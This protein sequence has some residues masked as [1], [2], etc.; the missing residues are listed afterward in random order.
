MFI[1]HL[2]GLYILLLQLCYSEWKMMMDWVLKTVPS[3]IHVES[4]FLLVLKS[5]LLF[6]VWVW[7]N[8]SP[9]IESIPDQLRMITIPNS[10]RSLWNP[11]KYV[12]LQFM[13]LLQKRKL[14]LWFGH[15]DSVQLGM[16]HLHQF[17]LPT[18]INPHNPVPLKMITPLL[19]IWN[20][21]ILGGS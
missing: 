15:Y 8:P 21:G 7:V 2:R 16:A 11:T 6:G 3:R 17:I 18:I 19:I 12:W 13:T 4:V 1:L 9:F 14:F 5:D 20:Q 10:T